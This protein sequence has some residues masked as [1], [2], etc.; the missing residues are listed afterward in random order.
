MLRLIKNELL[1]LIHR[2][3][4]YISFG[5]II[6]M[7]AAFSVITV[8]GKLTSVTTTYDETELTRNINEAKEEL[9]K[10]KT[11]EDKASA[12][13]A[14]EEAQYC[15]DNKINF[16]DSRFKMVEEYFQAKNSGDKESAQ[17]AD[18]IKKCLDTNEYRP[19]YEG[20]IKRTQQQLATMNPSS[21]EYK[22]TQVFLEVTELRLKQN[23]LKPYNTFVGKDSDPR[24]KY[25]GEYMLGKLD[26]VSYD[27]ASEEERQQINV[28]ELEKKNKVLLFRV[29]HNIPE[30]YWNEEASFLTQLADGNI[31]ILIL[32]IVIGATMFTSEFSYGTVSQLAIYPKKRYKII[33]SKLAVIMIFTIVMQALFYALSVLAAY[34]VEPTGANAFHVLF[35]Q[36]DTIFTLDFYY[37]LFVKYLCYF[38]EFLLY[39][40]IVLF[41]ALVTKNAAATIA[42]TLPLLLGVSRILAGINSML[43]NLQL[44]F[45]PFN[46][47]DFNQYID[48]KYSFA[49]YDLPWA[50]VITAATIA[51]FSFFGFRRIRRINI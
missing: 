50:I 37:Y 43:P 29:E 31:L 42:I 51:V 22:E 44:W 12:K 28:S 25:I 9:D 27:Y 5:L 20:L 21:R 17:W 19:Y 14:L 32:M 4:L 6:V 41:F 35:M 36:G 15:F 10:A 1:K 45:I 11:D 40:A 46:A 30:I 49:G 13:L 34:L 24:N 38:G 47:A 18:T 39:L 16:F 7:V 8:N 48:M 33:L 23:M 2:P 26:R 3:I